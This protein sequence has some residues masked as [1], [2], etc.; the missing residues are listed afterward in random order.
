MAYTAS[1]T[2][3]R[4]P[5]EGA[6]GQPSSGFGSGRGS[7]APFTERP[8]LDLPGTE[9]PIGPFSQPQTPSEAVGGNGDGVCV[10]LLPAPTPFTSFVFPI[11][12]SLFGGAQR[13]MSGLRSAG[14][15]KRGRH[16]LEKLTSW[17]FCR[18]GD[19]PSFLAFCSLLRFIFR[20]K[21]KAFHLQLTKTQPC[22]TPG[23]DQSRWAGQAHKQS[24]K[25]PPLAVICEVWSPPINLK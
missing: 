4:A 24:V 17:C 9:H 25:Q 18:P 23:V 8:T 16:D 14:A 3:L 5:G 20:M 12:S 10:P 15:C 22:L 1:L 11:S 6:T 19:S 2:F 7:A 13:H 21:T